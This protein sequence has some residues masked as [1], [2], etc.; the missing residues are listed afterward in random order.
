MAL[1][2]L[3]QSELVAEIAEDTG[4][5]RQNV[6]DVLSSLEESITYHIEEC[7][8]VRIGR[9]L[10]IEP[11][12]RA[13]TKSRMGRN[14]ATGEEIE[15]PAKPASTRVA[16]RVLAGLKYSAPSVSKLKKQL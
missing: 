11:K 3:S 13:R 1:P 2:L 4:L 10:Q 6:K 8:R 16:V 15:I 14:P 12:L 5:S 7:D 9:L